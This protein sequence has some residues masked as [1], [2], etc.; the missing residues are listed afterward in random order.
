MYTSNRA[1]RWNDIVHNLSSTNMNICL[2]SS[3]HK[4]LGLSTGAVGYRVSYDHCVEKNKCHYSD[5]SIVCSTIC[6]GADQK[7]HQSSSSL[8]GDRWFPSQRAMFPFD[9]TIVEP[10]P[11]AVQCGVVKM[12][13]GA[14][15]T[16]DFS[17]AFQIRWKFH[18]ALIASLLKWSLWNFVH[19][20]IAMLSWHVQNLVAI[21]YPSVELH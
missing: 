9:D 13:S 8:A 6:L 19:G 21:S 18:A 11:F 16:N 15:F 1:N 17:I 4:T 10:M 20:T 7:K 3:T 14:H 2:I 12:W 5:A